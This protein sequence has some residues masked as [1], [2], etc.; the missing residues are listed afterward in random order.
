MPLGLKDDLGI[1]SD[2][3]SIEYQKEFQ[4]ISEYIRKH[5]GMSILEYDDTSD[6]PTIGIGH[7]IRPGEDYTDFDEPAAEKLFRSD[8]AL[9]IDRTKS[10]FPNYDTYPT[11]VKKALVD[12]VFR[13]DYKKHHKTVKYIKSGQWDKVPTEYI[14]RKD[15][16]ASKASEGTKKP[17]TGVYKRLDENAALFKSYSDSL[18]KKPTEEPQSFDFRELNP[19]HVGEAEAAEGLGLKDDLGI[20]GKNKLDLKDDLGVFENNLGLQDD[21]GVFGKPIPELRA[22]P[23][24]TFYKKS[25]LPFLQKTGIKRTPEE[26]IGRSQAIYAD[27][28]TLSEEKNIPLR[29][30]MSYE[31]TK[32]NSDIVGGL[33]TAAQAITKLPKSV[34]T[35][36]LQA[37]QGAEGASVVDRNWTQ[38]FIQDAQTDAN[39]FVQDVYDRHKLTKIL[40]GV[41]IKITDIAELPQNLAFSITSMGA[42]AA[43]GLPIALIPVPGARAAAWVTGTAASGK[44]AYE[45]ATYQIMQQY[46]EAKN[47]ESIKEKGRSIT[48][49]EENRLKKDFNSE[50][51]KYGLWEAVPEALSNL[52][53]AKLLTAPLTKIAGKTT[54]GKIVERVSGIYGEELLTETITQKGQAAIEQRAGLREGKG[55]ITWGQAFKEVAPQ[56]FLLTTVMAGA[57]SSGVAIKNKATQMLNQELSGKQLTEEQKNI[58]KQELE[59]H[60]GKVIDESDKHKEEI[61]AETAP[62]APEPTPPTTPIEKAPPAK[63]EV[64]KE[65]IVERIT[66]EVASE[67]DQ[68]EKLEEI[69]ETLRRVETKDLEEHIDKRYESSA[70]QDELDLLEE[71]YAERI[72][73]ESPGFLEEREGDQTGEDGEASLEELLSNM[74]AR[75]ISGEAETAG[76]GKKDVLVNMRVNIEN[77]GGKVEN[78]SDEEILLAAEDLY[79]TRK[80]LIERRKAPK[81][82]PEVVKPEKAPPAKP[83]VAKPPIVEGVEPLLAEARKYK[84]AEE[85]VKDFQSKPIPMPKP[86]GTL[87]EQP[88]PEGLTSQKIKPLHPDEIALFRY[89]FTGEFTGKEGPKYLE[90]YRDLSPEQASMLLQDESKDYDIYLGGKNIQLMSQEARPIRTLKDATERRKQQLT[91]IWNKA[92]KELSPKEG[93]APP[94]AEGR[95]IQVLDTLEIWKEKQ[96]R[97]L[98]GDPVDIDEAIVSALK[99]LKSKGYPLVNVEEIADKH[100][101]QVLDQQKIPPKAEVKPKAKPKKQTLVSVIKASGGIDTTGVKERFDWKIDIQENKVPLTVFKKGGLPLDTMA[102]ELQSSGVLK[103]PDNMNPADYLMEQLKDAQARNAALYADKLD[104]E[105]EKEYNEWVEQRK[106]EGYEQREI[107]QAERELEA[108]IKKEVEG[109]LT[110][111]EIPEPSL[112]EKLFDIEPTIPP[113]PLRP[114]VDQVEYKDLLEFGKKP[115]VK[116]KELFGVEPAEASEIKEEIRKAKLRLKAAPSKSERWVL[117]QKIADLNRELEGL[118]PIDKEQKGDIL[119]EKEA[120]YGSEEKAD[121]AIRRATEEASQTRKVGTKADTRAIPKKPSQIVQEMLNKGFA[122]FKGKVVSSAKDVAELF[123]LARNPYIEIFQAIA[124]KN[125]EI[126]THKIVSSGHPA[127]ITDVN[128]TLQE[129]LESAVDLKADSI[130]IGHNHPGGDP[131]PSTEDNTITR[132]F[133]RTAN[134]YGIKMAGHITTDGKNFYITD[135]YGENLSENYKTPKKD[136]ARGIQKQVRNSQDVVSMLKNYDSKDSILIVLLTSQNGVISVEKI[137]PNAKNYVREISQILKD[138]VAPVYIIVGDDKLMERGK[139]KTLPHGNLDVISIKDNNEYVSYADSGLLPSLLSFTGVTPKT[140]YLAEKGEGY[141]GIIEPSEKS[142]KVKVAKSD[143][144]KIGEEVPSR[145]ETNII[146][147]ALKIIAPATVSEPARTGAL[148]LRKN[149]AELA[150]KDVLAIELLKK[151]HSAFTW[152]SDKDAHK[153]I[154]NIEEGKPQDN[155]KLQPFADTMRKL[156]DERR[157]GVQKLG[158]GQLENYYENYFPHIWKDPKNAKKVIASIMARKRLEGTK[159]FLKKRVIVSIKDGL[160]RKLELVSDNPVDLVLLKL[161]EMDRYIMAQNIVR[162]L[163]EKNLAKFVYSRKKA[164][165]G[166]SRINDNAFTV[167]M[168]PEITK[169][170]AYDSILVDQLMDIAK[171][172]GIDT[173]RFVSIGGKRWGYAQNIGDGVIR[174]KYAGPESVLVHEIGHVIGFRYG[175]YELIGRRKEGEWKVHEKGKKAGEEYFKPTEEAV[176]YRRTID[177]QWRDLADARWK[178]A[179]TSPGY[180]S[181]VRKAKEKEAVLLEALIHAPKEFKR[182]A[183][184]L[185]DGFTKFI[186]QHGELRPL[187]DVEP[188]LVLGEADAKIKIPGFTTLGHYYAP[189][190]VARLINNHLS[191]GLRNADNKLISGSYNILRGLGNVLNQVNLAL[192]GFHAINVSTDMMSSTLGLGLRKLLFTKGQRMSGLVDIANTFTAPIIRMW[193]GTRIRKAYRTQMESIKD[194][195]LRKMVE[196]VVTGGGRDRLD[197]YYY[198]R[199]IKALQK[200]FSEIIKGKDIEKLIGVAKLPFNMFGATLEVLAKPIM[201]WY[202]PTGKLGLFS[203]L[204]QHEMARAESGEIT[205]EQL[206]DRLASVWDSVDNRMGQLIYDNLFWNRVMKDG[207]MLNVRSTGWNLGSWREY[208]GAGIDLVTINERIKRG[209]KFF[210]QKMAYVTG[211]AIVYSTL[212]AIITYLLTGERPREIKDYF[213]PRTGRKNPDGS[214]ERLSLPTYAKDIYAYSQRPVETVKNKA[215]PLIGLMNEQIR[216]EDFFNIQIENPNDPWYNRIMSRAQHIRDYSKPFSFKNYEKMKKTGEEEG[217]ARFVSITGITSAPSYV[218]RSAAQKLMYRY[219]AEKIPDATR[220]K[221]E[222]ERSEYRRLLKNKLRKG[223]TIDRQEALQILGL[224]SYKRALKE[225]QLPPFS[226]AF[227]RLSIDEALNVYSIS[228]DK[229]KGQSREILFTKYINALKRGKITQDIKELYKEILI[230]EGRLR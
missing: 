17:F 173:K 14:N 229:E 36:V 172:M 130:F 222:G 24:E 70:T 157:E 38:R 170:E 198:N 215:H 166:Y 139:F 162:G 230:G 153:F 15:Y 182:V 223:E 161:H 185:Y 85:F 124:V 4:S 176:E 111:E 228:T 107:K 65:G 35:A 209:D 32:Y 160:A 225:A 114:K 34:A 195:K 138:N 63:P 104:S 143:Y 128:T 40:P 61:R 192:S 135:E 105:Y 93:V 156:L 82:T 11:E 214:D 103:V 132:E 164:P 146:K 133:T 145:E 20:L 120:A 26:E 37:H 95:E 41:P 112:D 186:N 218:T 118:T 181:Y 10:L 102:Q 200:T 183:P 29:D 46:L 121:E 43:A 16:R 66:K 197:V 179:K 199:Q 171:A 62:E 22:A 191:P 31:A 7:K 226:E 109:E 155:P 6:N 148:V 59:T 158:K 188:S 30:A 115:P 219:I 67:K 73:E 9:H 13:G 3:S 203:R 175:V 84:S 23:E 75:Y 204:A 193:E 47:E 206:L 87:R 210:S 211:A 127:S 19:F 180:K 122:T 201:E 27:A 69:K 78:I 174:T 177:K 208:A 18:K 141:G 224:D 44:A 184:D 190:D 221:E 45:M 97:G 74:Y 51:T 21:L 140:S 53:F 110:K 106:E 116:E 151:A 113:E 39:K 119:K 101:D 227:K 42:G 142:S 94:K 68:F 152:M 91:D 196:A 99:E 159:S 72:S 12:G 168:P 213:F 86:T 169:K 137:N 100:L 56:T 147:E 189:T 134:A 79:N 136:L 77:F 90:Y 60:I 154:D 126:V 92:Q 88:L 80:E 96:V 194:P 1:L 5:E 76:M 98:G 48:E 167:F 220:T 57:G 58:I 202:V 163:K 54:A 144:A 89:V 150:R 52:A 2:H 64:A 50:A 125:G 207:L 165:D 71:A 217:L 131:K 205:D 55:G 178:G 129:A 149:L 81:P 28:K 25:I 33:K 117:N 8:I 187:L 108:D 123:S 216:N 212:G 83:E 49:E